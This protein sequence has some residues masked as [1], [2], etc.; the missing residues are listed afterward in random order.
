MYDDDFCKYLHLKY[1][2]EE[3]DDF[4]NAKIFK[5]YEDLSNTRDVVY[6]GSICDT[7]SKCMSIFKIKSKP[8]V[9][10][11]YDKFYMMIRNSYINCKIELMENCLTY[12]CACLRP[13]SP[14]AVHHVCVCVS[15]CVYV[16]VCVCVHTYLFSSDAAQHVCVCVI[17]CVFVCLCVCI[18]ICS[19]WA[20]LH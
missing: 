2:A 8:R 4:K 14:D 7:L 1:D 6:I 17:L 18:H 19:K 20:P 3:N 12:V 15:V 13:F 9:N 10:W 5:I 16:Y 11:W